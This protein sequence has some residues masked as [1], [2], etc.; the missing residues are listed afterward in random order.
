MMPRHLGLTGFGALDAA[1]LSS[2]P[3][4]DGARK[5]MSA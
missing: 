4:I 3:G 5:L 1:F 2:R